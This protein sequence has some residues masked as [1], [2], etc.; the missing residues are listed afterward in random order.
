MVQQLVWKTGNAVFSSQVEASMLRCG[1]KGAQIISS[2]MMFKSPT[3][4]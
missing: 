4:D 2:D 3:L 1:K